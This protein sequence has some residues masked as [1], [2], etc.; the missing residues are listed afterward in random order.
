MRINLIMLISLLTFSESVG[1]SAKYYRFVKD[2][3][4]NAAISSNRTYWFNSEK[5]KRVID[6]NGYLYY[7][8]YN[9]AGNLDKTGSPGNE[10]P[11]KTTS[12]IEDLED[13]VTIERFIYIPEGAKILVERKFEKN[14]SSKGIDKTW[15][16]GTYPNN[17]V[18]GQIFRHFGGVD[19]GEP[20]AIRSLMKEDGKWHG[21]EYTNDAIPSPVGYSRP[22][23]CIDC[24]IN[25]GDSGH[26]IDDITGIKRDWYGV[27]G[28]ASEKGGPIVFH[29]FMWVNP[30]GSK[31]MRDKPSANP[32]VAHL[33]DLSLVTKYVNGADDLTQ[34][35]PKPVKVP[36]YS[37]LY[38]GGEGWCSYCNVL[39]KTMGDLEIVK[40]LES[41]DYKR[42]NNPPRGQIFSDSPT[43]QKFNI[44]SLPTVVILKD[45]K[46]IDRFNGAKSKSFMLS[47]LRKR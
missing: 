20:F 6:S 35:Y 37:L 22:D 2:D 31:L 32:K 26:E 27:V 5:F 34:L 40:E 7:H 42:F 12:G 36:V 46:E 10:Q 15:F 13:K 18:A 25:V 39:T 28:T 24:H 33:F 4:V 30:N 43:F 3:M 29:P 44:A 21:I 38:F 11:W 41:W 23:N 19:S 8:G 17:S 47:K 9:I 14:T 1:Q 16:H 45:G